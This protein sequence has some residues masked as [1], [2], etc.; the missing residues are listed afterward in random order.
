MRRW[1]PALAL[2][3][4][5]CGCGATARSSSAHEPVP[6]AVGAN[7]LGNASAIEDGRKLTAL[8]YKGESAPIWARMTDQLKRTMGNEETLSVLRAKVEA[9]FG[10]EENILDERTRDFWIPN[11]PAVPSQ[12]YTRLARFSKAHSLVAVQWR[13][14]SSGQVSGFSVTPKQ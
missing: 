2:V 6:A 4:S 3:G 7:G 8:F 9:Q 12:M 5:I 13:L 10:I 1:I 11:G 14:E